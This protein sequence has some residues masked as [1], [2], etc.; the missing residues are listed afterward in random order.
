[1]SHYSSTGMEVLYLVPDPTCLAARRVVKTRQFNLHNAPRQSSI[2]LWHIC[3]SISIPQFSLD[4]GQQCRCKL[5]SER[6]EGCLYFPPLAGEPQT[7]ITFAY[8]QRHG[9]VLPGP[10]FTVVNH[11][12]QDAI[13]L[14]DPMIRE[15][16]EENGMT[17]VKSGFWYLRSLR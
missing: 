8:S 4:A 1:M 13:S 5:A 6:E 16:V 11:D 2:R 14:Y 10:N 7:A 15:E 9:E 17:R 3:L 12:S